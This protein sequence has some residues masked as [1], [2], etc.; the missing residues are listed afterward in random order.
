MPEEEAPGPWPSA[1][2]AWWATFVAFLAFTVAHIDRQLLSLLVRPIEQDLH[3]S[4]SAFG[5]LQGL[6]FALF[7][8]FIGIPIGYLADRLSRRG[9]MAACI[10]VWCVMTTLTGYARSFTTL[11]I[12]RVGVGA[13]EGGLGPTA[14]SLISDLFPYDRLALPIGVFVLGNY[15]GSGLALILGGRLLNSAR[16][17]RVVLP[18]GLVHLSD[19]QLVFIAMGL[20]GLLLVP[21]SWTF[22]EPARR[23]AVRN[24]HRMGVESTAWDGPAF[25]W[26]NRRLYVPLVFGISTFG[27]AAIGILAWMPGF[28]IRTY[29]WDE[30]K[31]GT[32]I[33]VIYIGAGLIGTIVAGVMDRTLH[34][35][36]RKSPAVVISVCCAVAIVPI[37]A[38]FAIPGAP[39]W[40]TLGAFGLS[41]FLVAMP[42]ALI[43]TALQLLSP[44]RLRGQVS[45]L[46]VFVLSVVGIGFGPTLV[47]MIS[48]S[49]VRR[50][51][52]TPKAS[53]GVAITVTGAIGGV[54]CVALLRG[55]A[56]AYQRRFAAIYTSDG[57]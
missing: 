50:G 30:V 11:F 36:R 26:A 15:F 23:S 55:V 34:R 29:S 14:Y 41:T 20:P 33:G 4:D 32:L 13:G 43:P 1:G 35:R 5:A 51:L 3:L 57:H 28:L 38:P 53:L 22:R 39:P 19:W 46:Y 24:A 16:F 49:L 48:D 27:I 9:L 52:S 44:N 2:L 10:F 25:I 40:L 6:A 45:A 18:G 7:Y 31:A 56:D 47:G 12:A 54:L 37:G 8:T 21:L 17:L 42:F